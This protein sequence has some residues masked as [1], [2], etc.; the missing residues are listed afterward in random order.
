MEM[1]KGAN[2]LLRFLPELCALGT[3]GYWDFKTAGGWPRRWDSAS[4]LR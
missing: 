1:I 3:V 2:L 4:A